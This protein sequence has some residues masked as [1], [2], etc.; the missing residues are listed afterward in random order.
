MDKAAVEA[1]PKVRMKELSDAEGV[2]IAELPILPLLYYGNHNVVSPKLHGFVD[3][4]MDK[5]P[6][7]FISKD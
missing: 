6:S 1:D 2:M 4:V 3:N 5:H 7:R